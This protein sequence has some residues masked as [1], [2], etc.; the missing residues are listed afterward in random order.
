MDRAPDAR[1]AHR[2]PPKPTDAERKP[3]RA[4]TCREHTRR[5]WVRQA[6][7]GEVVLATKLGRV[8]RDG[9]QI[10]LYCVER[11]VQA[12]GRG[13]VVLPRPVVLSPKTRDLL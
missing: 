4:H 6:A 12:H 1:E 7:E 8:R 3:T 2:S 5:V 13:S 9:S 10:I 11:A